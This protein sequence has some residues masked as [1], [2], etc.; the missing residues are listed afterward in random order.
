M[1]ALI[2]WLKGLDGIATWGAVLSTIL[3]VR[4]YRKNRLQV[5]IGFSMASIADV[6]NKIIIRNNSNRPIIVTYWEI[7]FRR[8]WFLPFFES[9]CAGPDE[10]FTDFQ[11]PENSS[12]ILEFSAQDYFACNPKALKGRRLYFR[13]RVS[14]KRLPFVS[15]LYA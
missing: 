14:G 8:F 11:I 12:K 13:M 7:V 1:A 9:L 10:Y 5:E 2:E 15:F 4:E 6:G 3:A